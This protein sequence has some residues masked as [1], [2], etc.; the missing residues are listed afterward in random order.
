LVDSTA[1][2]NLGDPS[3]RALSERTDGSFT[4]AL[5]QT[6]HASFSVWCGAVAAQRL[7]VEMEHQVEHNMWK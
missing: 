5:F 2:I 6:Q 3:K 1:L 7:A 4:A